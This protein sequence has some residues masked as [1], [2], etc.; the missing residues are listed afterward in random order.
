LRKDCNRLL[1]IYNLL[2]SHLLRAGAIAGILLNTALSA[3]SASSAQTRQPASADTSHVVCS[4]KPSASR[5]VRTEVYASPDGHH[6]AYAEVEARALSAAQKGQS[7][8]SCVNN[9]R[10]FIATDNNN[11]QIAFLQ[12]AS[13]SETGNA[14]RIV[15]W[16]ADS[17][18]LLLELAQW[19]YDSPGVT[20]TP[21]IFDARH[22]VFQH[23]D[24][25]HALSKQFGVECSLQV[26]VS[27]FASDGKIA[28]ETQPLSPEEEEV[29]AL[30]TC[31]KKKAYWLLSPSSETL[32]ALPDAAKASHNA[33][34]ER[35]DK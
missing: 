9:S 27:G 25:N 24:L 18:R 20:N 23:F 28:L 15:D 14:L 32:A 29:L 2:V 10:L 35:A 4:E 5:T 31:A 7:G 17:R 12:E 26:R 19:S 11:F 13:D 6:R 3:Q 1:L 21:I 30:P 8:P 16:S 22:G 33:K 34:I